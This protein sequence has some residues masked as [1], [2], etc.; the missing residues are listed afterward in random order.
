MAGLDLQEVLKT[1]MALSNLQET[2]RRN[3]IYEQN[4][5][6][7]MMRMELDQQQLQVQKQKMQHDAAMKGLSSIEQMMSDPMISVDTGRRLQL[8]VA[9]GHILRTMGV[10]DFPLPD[11]VEDLMGG[12]AEPGGLPG[13]PLQVLDQHLDLTQRAGGLRAPAG[14]RGVVHP[15][16]PQLGGTEPGRRGGGGQACGGGGRCSGRSHGDPA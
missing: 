9:Q 7:N 10:K 5:L 8:R 15:G 2:R 4:A 11:N 6:T 3:D 16:D 14:V 13:D 1:G 12:A